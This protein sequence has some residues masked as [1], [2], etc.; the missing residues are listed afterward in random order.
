MWHNYFG[1]SEW[2]NICLI[3]YAGEFLLSA[4]CLVKS[5][6]CARSQTYKGCFFL[7]VFNQT[8]KVRKVGTNYYVLNSII[9]WKKYFEHIIYYMHSSYFKKVQILQ[10]FIGK[11]KPNK[12]FFSVFSFSATTSTAIATTTTATTATT[13]ATKS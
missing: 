7:K 4:H 5:T 13:S 12:A 11:R 3:L 6:S 10:I 2:R 1:E 8:N 9:S